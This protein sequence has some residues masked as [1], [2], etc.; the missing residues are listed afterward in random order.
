MNKEQLSIIVPVYNVELYLEE[1]IESILCQ[2][3]KNWELILVNDGSTDGSLKICERYEQIDSRI[4][5]IKQENKGVAAARKTG[6]CNANGEFVVFI[7]SDDYISKSYLNEMVKSIADCDVVMAGYY[8]DNSREFAFYDEIAHGLY[9]TEEEIKYIFDNMIVADNGERGILPYIWNK[10]YRK[11]LAEIAFEQIDERVAFGE[12]SEFLYKYLLLCKRIRIVRLSGYYYRVRND[13]VVRSGKN[14]NYL[15]NLHYLYSSLLKT[16]ESHNNSERLI[17]QLQ[18]WMTD[19]ILNAP[20][21][22]GFIESARN[23]FYVFP[24]SKDYENKKIVLYGAGA[25]GKDYYRQICKYGYC[26]LVGWTDK[27]WKKYSSLGNNIMSITDLE[28]IEYDNIIL[29]VANKGLAESIKNEL[30]SL[31][32]VKDRII[33]KEPI[34]SY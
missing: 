23:S 7:D 5:V 9:A 17:E 8:R 34:K 1:C 18:L 33:W 25:V 12:D 26:K 24:F 4:K 28:K 21:R 10:I 29:A 14:T 16:F 19:M 15:Q 6:V 32:V 20:A 11:E 2:S 22:M 3:F 13:S 27:N 30:I 31:G